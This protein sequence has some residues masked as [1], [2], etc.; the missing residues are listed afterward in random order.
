MTG[1]VYVITGLRPPVE[2]ECAKAEKE[3]A[4]EEALERQRAK[5]PNTGRI[6]YEIKGFFVL[7]Y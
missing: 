2:C 1:P 3:K 7:F 6:K 4:E 5:P